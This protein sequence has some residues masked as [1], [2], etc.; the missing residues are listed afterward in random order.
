[1]PPREIELG[2]GDLEARDPL[3]LD[4]AR[5]DELPALDRRVRLGHDRARPERVAAQDDVEVTAGALGTLAD[6]DVERG[7]RPLGEAAQ[8]GD[9]GDVRGPPE[10]DACALR[11]DRPAPV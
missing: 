9:P 10:I 5:P 3:R 8:L 4:L 7:A 6:V 2:A 11:A 1:E